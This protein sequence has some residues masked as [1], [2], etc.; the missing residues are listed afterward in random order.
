MSWLKLID[1][2]AEVF[3]YVGNW[4]SEDVERQLYSSDPPNFINMNLVRLVFWNR[5]NNSIRFEF[6]DDYTIEL[7]CSSDSE[8]R[9]VIE[10][11]EGPED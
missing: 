8:L 4:Q 10:A 2:E 7:V 9:R 5:D 11:V 3:R 6:A 1:I